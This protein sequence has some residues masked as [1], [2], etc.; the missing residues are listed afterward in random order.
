MKLQ[1][2]AFALAGAILWGGCIFF[3]ALVNLFCHAYCHQFLEL[4]SSWYPGY[5][6]SPTVPQ[7]I[8]VTLYA[9]CDGLIGAAIFAWLYNRFAKQSA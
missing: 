9:I 1:V 5:H 7:L 2:K 4:L 6:A 3:V 8:V